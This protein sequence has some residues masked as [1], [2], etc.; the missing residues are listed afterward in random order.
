MQLWCAAYS[1]SRR[2]S[3]LHPVAAVPSVAVLL[4]SMVVRQ[5]GSALKAA[6]LHPRQ[7][8]SHERFSR[9]I[10]RAESGHDCL[11]RARRLRTH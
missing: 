9:P 4:L 11:V 7:G 10:R 1:S 2:L 8:R 5:A 3:F 6:A